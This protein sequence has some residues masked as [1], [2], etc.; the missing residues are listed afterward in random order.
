VKTVQPTVGNS[1]SDV[2]LTHRGERDAL[3]EKI[4]SRL[5][6]LD[7]KGSRVASDRQSVAG[8]LALKQSAPDTDLISM[9]SPEVREKASKVLRRLRREL[10]KDPVSLAV[11]DKVRADLESLERSLFQEL[12]VLCQ[13]LL[14][15]HAEILSPGQV[16]RDFRDGPEMV[17]RRRAAARGDNSPAFRHRPLRRNLR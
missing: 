17:G 10:H 9:L 7:A 6:A 12:I 8:N 4:E 11:I 3:L 13:T 1:W 14:G 2:Y 15:H 5:Q 16:F